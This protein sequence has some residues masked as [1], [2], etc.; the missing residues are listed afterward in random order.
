MISTYP[1]EDMGCFDDVDRDGE[2][3]YE[4]GDRA[5]SSVCDWRWYQL[6]AV[7]PKLPYSI[8]CN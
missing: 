1:D 3:Q 6:K 8:E 5:F 2:F 4:R 7:A